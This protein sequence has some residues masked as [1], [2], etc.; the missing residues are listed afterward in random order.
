LVFADNARDK[1]VDF[2]AIRPQNVKISSAHKLIYYILTSEELGYLQ[3][4]IERPW[5]RFT[6]VDLFVPDV[7]LI[8]EING[9]THYF[10]SS[11]KLRP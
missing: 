9:P 2:T 10:E 5:N 8:I 1:L 7:G 3:T 11:G 6:N 4:E